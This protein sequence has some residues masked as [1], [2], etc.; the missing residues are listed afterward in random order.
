MERTR[1]AEWFYN[2]FVPLHS[3]LWTIPRLVTS[4]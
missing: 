4:Y 2:I 3:D 1:G